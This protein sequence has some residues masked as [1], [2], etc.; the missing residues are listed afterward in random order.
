MSFK[1]ATPETE[2]SPGRPWHTVVDGKPQPEVLY[3]QQRR[4]ESP[5]DAIKRA[6]E[7]HLS[8]TSARVKLEEAPSFVSEEPDDND[9]RY[10]RDVVIHLDTVVIRKCQMGGYVVQGSAGEF[11]PKIRAAFT[12]LIEALD[13]LAVN[14]AVEDERT[15][16]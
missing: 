8:G 9:H 3:V 11:G 12:S 14:V 1:F 16:D 4:G 15:R 2:A 6:L 10:H 7:G 5:I 13:W